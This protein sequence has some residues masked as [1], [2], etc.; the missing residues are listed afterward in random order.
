MPPLLPEGPWLPYLVLLVG[1]LGVLTG[2]ALASLPG[3]FG[4][5]ALAAPAP[6]VA[7][8]LVLH[9]RRRA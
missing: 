3:S 1:A 5:H 9:A 4:L 7:A 6:L 2:V 8:L